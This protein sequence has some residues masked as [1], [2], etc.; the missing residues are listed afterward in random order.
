VAKEGRSENEVV[1][2]IN[3]VANAAA[4]AAA[5]PP[6]NTAG[7]ITNNAANAAGAIPNVAANQRQNTG[8]QPPQYKPTM[9]KEASADA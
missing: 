1:Q 4:N 6:A 3:P 7:N 9:L 5:N 2:P 8:A